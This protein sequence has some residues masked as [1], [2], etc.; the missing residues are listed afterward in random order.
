M[1]Y[2]TASIIA[3]LSLAVC[4]NIQA[5]NATVLLDYEQSEFNDGRDLPA[6]TNFNLVGSINEEIRIVKITI[7][8]EYGDTNDDALY[9]NTWKRGLQNGQ[10]QFFIPVNYKLRGG[11]EY[12]FRISYYREV[13]GQELTNFRNELF[14]SLNAYIDQN[15]DFDKKRIELFKSGRSMIEDMN[16]IVYS[17][18]TYYENSSFVEF[19]GFSDLVLDKIDLISKS[20]Q[21]RFLGRKSSQQ[22]NLELKTKELNELKIRVHS[23]VV[24]L[25]NDNLA[26]IVD[27][28]FI[29]N[30]SVEKTRNPLVIHGG[31][32]GAFLDEDVS[33]DN[34]ASSPML[35]LTIPLGKKAF[36]SKFW[37]NSAIMVGVYYNN[38]DG[39]NGV[40]VTGPVVKRPIYVGYGYKIYRFIRL[41]AGV[42][43]LEND[44]A[45]STI[46]D[47]SDNI[48]FRPFIGI[49]ADLNLF[50]ELAK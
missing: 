34:I 29:D 18:F 1:K 33:Q 13:N 48:Y 50:L 16:S 42:T 27:T 32:G 22:Q 25:I 21:N 49:T 5:Q 47:L 44:A 7:Y 9:S 6:E 36:A 31:Y 2:F 28:K 35:G 26:I 45:N 41:S 15:T 8:D 37:S 11:D 10:N 12:D 39:T 17:A 46:T 38:F 43:V 40:E 23:E 20:N 3:Y 19:K 4:N 24:G 30:Y 14:S